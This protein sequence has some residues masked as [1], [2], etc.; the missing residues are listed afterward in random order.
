[1]VTSTSPRFADIQDHWAKPFIE[2][3]ASRGIISGFKDGTFR[4]N[5][6]ITRAQFAALLL[7]AFPKNNSRQYVTFVDVPKEHWAA[8]AI[9]KAYETEFLSG[10]PDK[11]FRPDDNIPR[12]QALVSLVNGLGIASTV[13]KLKVALAEIYQDAGDIPGYA[14]DAVAVATMAGMVINYP[15]LES[16]KP[17]FG[18]TR[19]QVAAFIYQT[20]V[21]QGKADNIAF[22]FVVV[23][24]QN[25]GVKPT[26]TP[27]PAPAP[28]PTPTP[29]VVVIPTPVPT[30]APA[31]APSPVVV[32]P[33]PTPAPAPKPTPTPTPAPAPTPSAPQ[34]VSVSHKREFRGAY[35]PAVSGDWPSKQGLS[36]DQQKAELV[37]L[38]DR[39]QELN[40]NAVIFQVRAEGDA[41]YNSSLEPWSAAL[42]G[43]QGKA[44]DYDPLQ[45]AIDECRKRNLELHAWFNLNRARLSSKTVP[46]SPHISVTNPEA[47]YEYNKQF[48]MNPGEKVVQD[49]AYDVIMDVVRRYDVDGV[50]INDSFYPYP[51]K[52]Q[53]IGDS[54][55]YD[56]YKAGGGTLSIGDW[57]RD[58]INKVIKRVAEGIRSAKSHVKF[59]ISPFG[60]YRPGQPAQ[61]KGM[62]A[63]N[64]LFADSKKWLAEGW[65]D[66]LAPQLIWRTDQAGQ[67][68]P[69]LLEWWTQNNPKGKHIYA[70]N[71]LAQLEAKTLTLDEVN[72]QVS[73][74]R[75]LAEKLSL[76]NIFNNLKMLA[77]NKEGITDNLKAGCYSGPALVP[78]LSWM[79]STAPATPAGV[80]AK[81]GK[82][83]WNSG[84]AQVRSWSV[85][86]QEG[87]NWSLVRVLP[88]STTSVSVAP[89]TYAVCA[90]GRLAQESQGAVVAVR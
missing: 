69:V 74:T 12:V 82:L 89:G 28:T 55:T 60:I 6:P 20:L 32:T 51:V 65:V 8:A 30:P 68:Y 40:F 88:A 21:H 53:I 52:D 83:T 80:S 42:T 72:N 43:T 34:V 2:A 90:V 49:R 48:W 29:P 11:R 79:S 14:T 9:Q 71:S 15:K 84:S 87:S 27:A 66:F 73:L 17:L 62:D 16:L 78:T 81:D 44:P 26:P 41:L 57:R 56:A 39:L 19:A 37:K 5:D 7:K 3:L 24:P 70:G 1:M 45:F 75:S 38:L 31:P 77:E 13:P 50:H 86:K 54:K 36:G 85:Y 46:V 23:P 22:D 4:P 58:N 67:S 63:Y 35:I 47:V 25:I 59:G 64:E 61:I 18:A 10:Y 33:T 76:G